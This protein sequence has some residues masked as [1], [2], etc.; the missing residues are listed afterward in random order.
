MIDTWLNNFRDNWLSKNVDAVLALFTDTVEYWETPYRRIIGVDALR[1]EWGAILAQNNVDLKF[2][3]FSSVGDK[4]TVLWSLLYVNDK[5]ENQVWAGTY[6]IMLDSFGK[7]VYFH[8]TGEK[9]SKE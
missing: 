8:Q 2:D 3:T 6:L 1:A 9:Q 7:C 5:A 4:H